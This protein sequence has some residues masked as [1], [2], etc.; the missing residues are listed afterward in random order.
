MR[1]MLGTL[2]WVI[3]KGSSTRVPLLCYGRTIAVHALGNPTPV[4]VL[5]AQ[6]TRNGEV[7]SF[8][9][10]IVSPVDR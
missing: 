8:V 4:L 10:C 2:L 9:S 3:T 5:A 1:N 7:D 6:T